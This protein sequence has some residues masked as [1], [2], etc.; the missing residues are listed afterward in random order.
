VAFDG[1]V[2]SM[3]SPIDIRVLDQPLYLLRAPGVLRMPGP[4]EATT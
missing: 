2:A 4:L 3:R 1:E